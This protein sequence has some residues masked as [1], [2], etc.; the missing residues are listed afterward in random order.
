MAENNETLASISQTEG[1]RL[2]SLLEYNQLKK[3]RP[4]TKGE[5]ILLRAPTTPSKKPAKE[6]KK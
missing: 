1:I 2:E 4:L 3:E 5:K 6:T